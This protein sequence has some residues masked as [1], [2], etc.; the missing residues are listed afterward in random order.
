MHTYYIPTETKS[1]WNRF[2]LVLIIIT[3]YKIRD[4]HKTLCNFSIIEYISKVNYHSVTCSTYVIRMSGWLLNACIGSQYKSIRFFKIKPVFFVAYF[5]FLN[6]LLFFSLFSSH[7]RAHY[8][9]T[10]IASI[11]S[12]ER[13][14]ELSTIQVNM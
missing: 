6:H 1:R 11:E 8:G 5:C 10:I 2:N 9:I 13:L 3:P 12:A 14:S 4:S 7:F